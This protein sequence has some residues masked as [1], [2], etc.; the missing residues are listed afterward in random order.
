M[1]LF[2]RFFV[3]LVYIRFGGLEAAS[4]AKR[5]PNGANISKGRE[6]TRGT[7]E[8]EGI[9]SGSEEGRLPS[10]AGPSGAFY[11]LCPLQLSTCRCFHSAQPRFQM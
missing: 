11:W 6:K 9:S 1:L 8:K 3:T 7:E 10:R 4:R 5:R 2:G